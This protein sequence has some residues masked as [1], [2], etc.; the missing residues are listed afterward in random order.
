MN[1]KVIIAIVVILVIIAVILAVPALMTKK[2][3]N[4][5]L[6][7]QELNTSISEKAPFNEMATMD[8]DSEVLSVLYEINED[9]YE[10]VVGKMPMTNVQ[11]SMYLVIK[12]KDESVDTV[13]EKVEAY[14]SAQERIWSTYLPEQYELVKQR[15]LDVI[16]NYVYLVISENASEIEEI[17]KK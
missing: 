15:K 4:V 11:A 9:Q 2:T 5:E 16:G 3:K 10:E 1:K 13:K 6:N 14:A 12:A 7:L 17:I 8:I